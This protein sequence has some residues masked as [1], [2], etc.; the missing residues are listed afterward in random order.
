MQNILVNFR[1]TLS[2]WSD[3]QLQEWASDRPSFSTL[4]IFLVFDSFS[5]FNIYGWKTF[6]F[7]A[8]LE[9]DFYAST[10]VRVFCCSALLLWILVDQIALVFGT[11]YW[12]R[13]S[14]RIHS[15]TALKA[16]KSALLLGTL[17]GIRTRIELR[18][19]IR[20]EYQEIVK[21]AKMMHSVASLAEDN[22]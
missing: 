17:V 1:N 19:G 4:S 21:E 20:N 18:I 12:F 15:N 9:G 16:H 6:S 2:C 8:H 11:K 22:T 13:I 7:E 3:K 5:V 14:P 10:L